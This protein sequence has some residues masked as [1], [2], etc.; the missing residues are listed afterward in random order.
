MCGT[1]YGKATAT[2]EK[3]FGVPRLLG[4]SATR[5]ATFG[6]VPPL[7]SWSETFNHA[8]EFKIDYAAPA[9]G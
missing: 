6:G 9:E 1:V 7:S 5:T 2:T 8:L 4:A 3:L